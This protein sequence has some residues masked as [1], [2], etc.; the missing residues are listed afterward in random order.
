M[1][2]HLKQRI[3]DLTQ[4]GVRGNVILDGR[5]FY[6]LPLKGC[7]VRVFLAADE[8]VIA[9]DDNWQIMLTMIGDHDDQPA[10]S[11]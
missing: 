11:P 3:H 6:V 5:L 7:G 9:S 1:T 8:L 10:A 2:A 4:R